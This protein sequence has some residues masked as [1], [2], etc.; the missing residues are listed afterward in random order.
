[1]SSSAAERSRRT[2]STALG[3]TRVAGGHAQAQGGRVSGYFL[4]AALAQDL[5]RAS[6]THSTKTVCCQ[7]QTPARTLSPGQ[8]AQLVHPACLE[9]AVRRPRA[10]LCCGTE[11]AEGGTG[12]GSG[13]RVSREPRRIHFPSGREIGMNI[14]GGWRFGVRLLNWTAPQLRAPATPRAPDHFCCR[15]RT[16]SFFHAPG[17]RVAGSLAGDAFPRRLAPGLVTAAGHGDCVGPPG[18]AIINHLRAAAPQDRPCGWLSGAFFSNVFPYHPAHSFIQ[19]LL[20]PGPTPGQVYAGGK[21][22]G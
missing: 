6:R 21:S 8:V 15:S 5:A 1:M 17:W 22:F 19:G 14:D 10:A 4:G 7:M 12:A 3:G 16:V 13:D 11:L 18:A 9:L 2:L 20:H